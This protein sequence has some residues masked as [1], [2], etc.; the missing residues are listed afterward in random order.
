[1]LNP[2]PFHFFCML[3]LQRLMSHLIDNTKV[4]CL[5]CRMAQFAW[6][7]EVRVHGC[8]CKDLDE[9]G[10][11]IHICCHFKWVI[12]CPRHLSGLSTHISKHNSSSPPHLP[13]SEPASSFSWNLYYNSK[14]TVEMIVI[15]SQIRGHW[16]VKRKV[17]QL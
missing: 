2:R 10:K 5:V 17:T 7:R 12:D 8:T 9:G 11:E 16:E 6:H 14:L 1:M 15:S 3:F 4:L 13:T